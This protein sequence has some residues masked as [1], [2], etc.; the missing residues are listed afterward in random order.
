ME[1]EKNFSSTTKLKPSVDYYGGTMKRMQSSGPIKREDI[2][3]NFS[4]DLIENVWSIFSKSIIKNY[5]SGKGT[6]IPKFGVFTYNNVEVNLEGTTNQHSRDLK[7]RKPVFIVSSEFVEKLRPGIYTLNNGVTYYSQKQNGNVGHVRISYAEMSYSMSL[8]KEEV[9]TI[10]ENTLKLIADSIL[11]GEFRNKELPGVGT[12]LLRGNILAV[13]F[14]ENLIENVKLIPQKLNLTKKHV[15]LFMEVSEKALNGEQGLKG[16][17]EFPNVAKSLQNLRPK[18]SVVTKITRKGEQ[19]LKDNY[20]IDLKEL[21]QE[22]E[23]MSIY[24]EYTGQKVDNLSSSNIF[25]NASM[26]SEEIKNRILNDVKNIQVIRPQK[27]EELNFP[28]NILQ[29]IYFQKNLILSE[30]KTMDKLNTG[31]L[32][33]YEFIH[34]FSKANVQGLSPTGITEIMNLYTDLKIDT[35]NY[36]KVMGNLLKEIKQ[37][38]NYKENNE[39]SGSSNL[40]SNANTELARVQPKIFFN[41]RSKYFFY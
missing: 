38:I 21:D 6:V 15:N 24:K 1:T 31:I 37:I 33:K 35:V 14:D 12:I 4:L 26:S 39:K 28:A 41:K 23:K 17:T 29:S 22:E 7:A 20:D 30:L 25:R 2:L 40:N 8:K 3:K 10:M 9:T 18:T 34:G 16:L 19:W 5:Q 32:K 13:K 11:R 36:T 27:L